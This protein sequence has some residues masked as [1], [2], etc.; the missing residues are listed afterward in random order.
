MEL[1]LP[2]SVLM[3]NGLIDQQ[4]I[5]LRI[6]CC[7]ISGE[8]RELLINSLIDDFLVYYNDYVLIELRDDDEKILKQKA[9]KRYLLRNK[10]ECSIVGEMIVKKDLNPTITSFTKAKKYFEK[11]EESYLD[12]DEDFPKNRAGLLSRNSFIDDESFINYT[13]KCLKKDFNIQSRGGCVDL[14]FMFFMQENNKGLF[15]G[16]L[17]FLCEGYTID[18]QYN[19]TLEL[20][21][22][23]VFKLGEDIDNLLATISL[24]KGDELQEKYID[25]IR[26]EI[27]EK[28]E[29]EPWEICLLDNIGWF[30]YVPKSIIKREIV[31]NDDHNVFVQERTKGVCISLNKDISDLKTSDILYLRRNYLNQYL[32]K[33]KCILDDEVDEYSCLKNQGELYPFY[34]EEIYLIKIRDCGRILYGIEFNPSEN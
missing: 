30:N 22:S 11:K 9:V 33:V 31:N 34:D 25:L 2:H 13:K 5:E 26:D 3:S 32:L 12:D 27:Y 14:S 4:S 21:K 28:Y 8:E 20:W 10:T 17:I 6:K 1:Y 16:E 7:G 24:N 19:D 29:K 15:D 18:Y 23:F